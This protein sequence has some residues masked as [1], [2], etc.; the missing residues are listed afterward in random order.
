MAESV[1]AEAGLATVIVAD[2][3]ASVYML[4]V[5]HPAEGAPLQRPQPRPKERR[6]VPVPAELRDSLRAVW[7]LIEQARHDPDI[8]LDFDDAIQV[9]AVCG[10]R[11]G[12]PPRP[13]VLTYHPEGDAERGRWFLSLH[14]TEIEDIADGCL[15]EMAMYCCTSP[16]CRCKF[17][18]AGENCSYCDYPPDPEYGHL[19]MQAALP[20]LA[21]M[22]ISGL[23]A[24]ATR[25]HVVA[26][27]GEPQESG[28]G[29]V[30]GDIGYIKPWIKYR[31]RDHQLRFEFDAQGTVEAVTFMPADWRPGE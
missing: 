30:H 26:A 8:V 4:R 19:M 31:R 2:G 6:R 14:W 15:T 27:L 23:S 12:K 7:E 18:E 22:G 20:R 21:E 13:Y 9:G 1:R 10:G 5:D 29:V 28:G 17:R 3:P 24:T 11:I 16:E 25:D